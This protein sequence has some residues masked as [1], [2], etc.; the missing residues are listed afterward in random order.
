M[1]RFLHL[2]WV[3]L[4]FCSVAVFCKIQPKLTVLRYTEAFICEKKKWVMFY[5][6][7]SLQAK[8]SV[9]MSLC[10]SFRL[11]GSRVDCH[12]YFWLIVWPGV[13]L[14]MFSPEPVVTW[15]KDGRHIPSM[16]RRYQYVNFH[17]ELIIEDIRPEDEGTYTCHGTNDIDTTQQSFFL[18]VQGRPKWRY[19]QVSTVHIT[20][21]VIHDAFNNRL[22]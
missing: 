1:W 11:C 6:A 14:A 13:R 18:D 15:R 17:T 3:A 19:I 4:L 9:C 10:L 20:L 16:R 22:I 12:R 21:L 5:V 8:T 7:T 2:D